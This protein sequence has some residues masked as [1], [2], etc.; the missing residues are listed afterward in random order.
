MQVNQLTS[1]ADYFFV[2][3]CRSTRQVKAVAEHIREQGKKKGGLKVLGA[4]GENQ[5]QWA[6]VDFGDVVA[7]V[8]HE[9]LRRFYDLESLWFEAPRIDIGE[10]AEATGTGGL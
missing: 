6:L 10:P 5:G 4:E 7:H 1:I 8:F 2:C 3:S 9:P